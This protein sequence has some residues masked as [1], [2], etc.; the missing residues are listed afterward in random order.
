MVEGP[1]PVITF[2]IGRD[3]TRFQLLTSNSVLLANQLAEFTVGP[4]SL[5]AGSC[6][7]GF[8]TVGR[9]SSIKSARLEAFVMFTGLVRSN[10]ERLSGSFFEGAKCAPR[11]FPTLLP[12]SL[13]SFTACQQEINDSQHHH[14]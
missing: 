7:V 1:S 12:T 9:S 10:K 14:H 13:G 11:A 2:V 3:Q 6:A 4:P 8:I 5:V